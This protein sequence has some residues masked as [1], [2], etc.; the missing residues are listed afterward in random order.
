MEAV[1]CSVLGISEVVSK[2]RSV[3]MLDNTLSIFSVKFMR[4]V[5]IFSVPGS[6]VA[7]L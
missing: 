7:V 5:V 1:I 4:R 3:A 2:A 6:G